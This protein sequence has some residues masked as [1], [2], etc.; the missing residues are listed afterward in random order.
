MEI[1]HLGHAC[2]RIDGSLVIDLYKDGG[3]P[4]IPPLRTTASKV[5]CSH[6]HA[7]HVGLTDK[8]LKI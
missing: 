5:I 2:F 8:I 3:V 7:D 1:E 6:Q 4:N